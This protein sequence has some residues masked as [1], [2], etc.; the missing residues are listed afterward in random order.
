L[1]A[2]A[3]AEPAVWSFGF[4]ALGFAVFAIQLAIAW[5]GG[6]RARWLL[7]AVL[8]S[9]L[10]A[11]AG[12]G[13]VLTDDARM[14]SLSRWLELA[15]IAAWSIFLLLIVP[16][17]AGESL[18]R[19]PAFKWLLIALP[20]LILIA[21][22]LPLEPLGLPSPDPRTGYS[23]MVGLII[24]QLVLLE[25]VWRNSPE[26]M[27][28]ALKPLCLGLGAAFSYNLFMYAEASLFGVLSEN[29]WSAHAATQALVIPF[30][31][32]SAARNKQWTLNIHMSRQVVFHSTALLG[33]GLYL[34]LASA[35]GY[36][37]RFFGGTWGGTLQVALLFGALLLL[38]ML[39]S[40]GTLRSKLRVFVNKNF[41]SY[42]YDYRAEWLRFTR[43]LSSREA[44]A[45][46]NEMSVRALA[47]LVESTGGSLW[48]RRDG[49]VF[50]QV[51]RWNMPAVAEAE[52]EDGALA[53]FL[54]RTGW[55][56][57]LEEYRAQPDR[58]SGLALPSWLMR[59]DNA[60]IVLP[61]QTAEELT[62]FVLL[63]NP[64][65]KVDINWEVLDL[66]KTAARQAASYLGHVHAAEALMEARK[67]DAFNRMSAFVVHDLKNLVAQLNLMIKNAERHRDNPEFQRDMLDTV[68]HVASR[69]NHLLMQ[70]RA[71][72]TPI[73]NAKTVD[74]GEIVR[75][76]QRAKGV[77][78][79]LNVETEDAAQVFGHE[80]RLE[81][82][83]GHLVQNAL[84]ATE[85]GG[86][87]EVRV[88]VAGKE[89]TLLEVKDNGVGMS[90]EFVRERLFR[91]F[92]ST[93][94]TG[95]GIGAYE[96]AQ[97]L[98]SIGARIQVDSAPNQGTR[99]Q[100]FLPRSKT[101]D[102]NLNQ[103]A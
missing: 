24:L 17:P 32:I 21:A 36:Y 12:L 37:I 43:L 14:W 100:V 80:D 41:F 51:S 49:N 30:V 96:S 3:F 75:R 28:W 79:R 60:W 13:F 70:L 88:S 68:Q 50:R 103:A 62:G 74:L 66:L 48:L 98:Q 92:Q 69:M 9:A 86:A 99:I 67:F 47:D 2:T 1:N 23:A 59:Q 46:L 31:A 73:E 18:R 19:R 85:S 65:T 35:V 16:A 83:V 97:Y 57:N 90:P 81:H 87:V 40:S 72:A 93:K 34:L 91:P 7:A 38:G 94:P 61:L 71:G 20:L 8:L 4:A 10:W 55:V 78:E 15:Q 54:A 56:V 82:V 63:A 25:Q 84:D 101:A 44:T 27:R 22:S 39:F 5:R 102:L 89:E 53:A 29:L 26:S 52:P 64:R 42:R 33:C 58:Y 45:N 76:T 77:G 11:I 95:M 6:A